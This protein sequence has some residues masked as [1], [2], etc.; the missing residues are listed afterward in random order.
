MKLD[1]A[2]EKAAVLSLKAELEKAKAKAQEIQEAAL[3]TERAA[4]ERRVLETE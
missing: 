4:Y 2:M 1:L 3:A